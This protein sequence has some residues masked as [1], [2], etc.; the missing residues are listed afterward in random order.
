MKTK[1]L[2]IKTIES[3]YSIIIG[4]NTLGALPKKIKI[5]C[6]KTQKIAIIF[7]KNIPTKFK[8]KIKKLLIGYQV[9]LYEFRSN[10]KVKSFN[11]ANKIIEKILSKNFNRSDTIIAVGGGIIGDLSA[12]VASL[13]KRGINFINIPTTLLAQVDSSIGGK[14][15]VNSIYGKN[16]IGSF[17]QPK[18]VVIDVSFLKS[19]PKREMICGFAEILKHSLILETNLFRWLENTS[20]EILNNRNLNLISEAI[21]KSCKVK[22]YFIKKDYKEKNLRMILNFGHTFAHAIEAENKFSGKINHG[23]AVLI[24]MIMA[25]R[26]SVIKKICSNQSLIKIGKIYK[27]NNLL[28]KFKNYLKNKNFEKIINYMANDKK[29]DDK[30][31]NLILLKKIG[32]AEINLNFKINKIYSFLNQILVNKI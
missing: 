8:S 19:L 30:K 20:K 27:N 21:Y 31:I 9:Y 1:L 28:S 16:L 15:G 25:I 24:G 11:Y 6:P 13:V 17:Y 2:K 12:F 23:E 5:L 3:D 32:K 29:N 10:E 14:T 22:L 18:L 26:L 4:D 7:D